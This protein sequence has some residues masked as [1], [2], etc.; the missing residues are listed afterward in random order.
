MMEVYLGGN[1]VCAR[2]RKWRFPGKFPR[3]ILA[4]K[5][6]GYFGWKIY[7]KPWISNLDRPVVGKWKCKETRGMRWG[8]PRNFRSDLGSL[9]MRTV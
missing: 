8:F 1:W 3:R 2:D 4:G 6:S 5:Y 7:D 9:K